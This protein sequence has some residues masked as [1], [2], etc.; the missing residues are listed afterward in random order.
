MV[1]AL[2][3][4]KG[5]GAAGGAVVVADK[6]LADTIFTCGRPMVFSGPR[7]PAQLGASITSARL[8]LSPE[9]SRLQRSLT[10]RIRHFDERARQLGVV[11]HA[12]SCEPDSL[13]TPRART[14]GSG[15][16]WL[17]PRPGLLRQR[18]DLP[19]SSSGTLRD[20]SDADTNPLGEKDIDGLLESVA[21][22]DD[23]SFS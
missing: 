18:N 8:H 11:R 16:R 14:P 12:C 13:P 19:R 7:Q 21:R 17:A 4:S 20:P 15:P 1:V 22:Y 5:L 2:S 3:F 9:L 6:Q 23:N 10:R